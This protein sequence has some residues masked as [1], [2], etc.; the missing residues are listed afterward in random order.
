MR[1]KASP[2]VPSALAGNHIGPAFKRMY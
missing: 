1:K 2:A